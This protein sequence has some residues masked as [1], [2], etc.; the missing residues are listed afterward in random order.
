MVY[1]YLLVLNFL[2]K[3]ISYLAPEVAAGFPLHF[4]PCMLPHFKYKLL[5]INSILL[6]VS[7][8]IKYNINITVTY[9]IGIKLCK[10]VL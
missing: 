4:L 10:S 5:R 7:K 1:M 3:L 8:K 9:S 2:S 6:K